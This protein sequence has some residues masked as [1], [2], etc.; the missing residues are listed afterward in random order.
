[1]V[2]TPFLWLLLNSCSSFF[3]ALPI[4][5]LSICEWNITPIRISYGPRLTTPRKVS[6]ALY[7]RFYGNK[8]NGLVCDQYLRKL[9]NTERKAIPLLPS[10]DVIIR[11][12][13]RQTYVKFKNSRRLFYRTD[14]SSY[15]IKAWSYLYEC[16]GALSTSSTSTNSGRQGPSRPR[17]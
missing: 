16:R 5:K 10:I 4:T 2:Y 1:M 12:L 7:F 9:L 15:P 11:Q 14:T 8:Q 3:S 13:S 17:E 6:F